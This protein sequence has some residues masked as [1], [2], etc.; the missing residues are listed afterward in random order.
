MSEVEREL[1]RDQ[2]KKANATGRQKTFRLATTKRIRHKRNRSW[3]MQEGLRDP[4]KEMSD[5]EVQSKPKLLISTQ[6]ETV[7]T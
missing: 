5:L 4:Q 6:A 7:D 2:S 3:N 1:E